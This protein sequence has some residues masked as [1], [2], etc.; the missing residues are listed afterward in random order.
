MRKRMRKALKSPVA[1]FLFRFALGAVASFFYTLGLT[2]VIPLFFLVIFP[3]RDLGIG[4]VITVLMSVAFVSF[5]FFIWYGYTRSL[6]KTL[7]H[8]SLATLIPSVIAIILNFYSAEVFFATI[9]ASAAEFETVR[10]LLESYLEQKVPK[11]TTIIVGYF[12]IGLGL[13]VT[14]FSMKK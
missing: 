13:F 7:Y 5:A 12:V 1:Q 10:P 6:K 11:I 9:Q 4:F 8:L 14:S 2:M 3:Y